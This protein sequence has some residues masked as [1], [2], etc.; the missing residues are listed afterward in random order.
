MGQDQKKQLARE[1]GGKLKKEVVYVNLGLIHVGLWQKTTQH[2]IAII[3]QLKIKKNKQERVNFMGC[4]FCL[5]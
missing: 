2:C 1:V 5:N 3:L 4:E